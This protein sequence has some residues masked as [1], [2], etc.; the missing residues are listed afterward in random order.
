MRVCAISD[1]HGYLP[2]LKPCDIVLICGDVIPLDIQL[3]SKES[4]AW[5]KGIFADWINKLPCDTVFM[6]AGNHDFYLE[7]INNRKNKI[8]ET[9]FDPTNGKLIYLNGLTSGGVIYGKY[10][11]WGTPFC[12]IFNK[13]AF[14]RSEDVLRE[15]YE[16]MPDNCDIVLSHDSP[17]FNGLGVLGEQWNYLDA[18]NPILTT[19]ILNKKPKYFF[20]G[21]LHEGNHKFQEV[22]GINCANVSIL[23][24]DY[25]VVYE[26]LYFDIN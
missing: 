4:E 12:K 14:M 24:D 2:T 19:V 25:E 11:I 9:L 5:F 23:N 10:L 8:K 21:H 22:D 16:L 6:V 26:P 3:K 20:S 7:H 18:G 17:M 15:R 1:L 13:W